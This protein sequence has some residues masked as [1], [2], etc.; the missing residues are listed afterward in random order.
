[1]SAGSAK[2]RKSTYSGGGNDCVEVATNLPGV[3]GVRDSENPGGPAHWF[4]LSQWRAF[5]A[6][7][8]AGEF[9]V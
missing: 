8:R 2:W 5:I 9:D 4:T 1:M 6:G 3:V 7:A